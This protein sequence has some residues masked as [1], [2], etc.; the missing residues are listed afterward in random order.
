MASR[1]RFP[2][3]GSTIGVVALVVAMTGAAY[4]G[5]GAGKLVKTGDIRNNAVTAPKLH[6]DAVRTPKIADD[7]VK[8][9][10]VDEAT[11]GTVPTAGK[12]LNV[13]AATIRSDGTLARASQVAGTSSAR[14]GE[15]SYVVDFGVGISTC[16][17]TVS[18]GG[19]EGEPGGEVSTSLSTANA[20][21]VQTRNSN[22]A[23]ADRA[24]SL[25]VVC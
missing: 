18:L 11:L 19:L 10:K 3:A 9:N 23:V 4:A 7:A 12:A 25:M 22:G 1:K 20:V 17:Y 5:S 15:G 24:F 13:L 14:N 6:A 2:S 16:T 8:G 21:A